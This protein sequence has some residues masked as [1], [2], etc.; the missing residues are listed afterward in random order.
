[1]T[2][3]IIWVLTAEH[4]NGWLR[5]VEVFASQEA[6]EKRKNEALIGRVPEDTVINI[7]PKKLQS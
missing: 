7:N 2:E 3:Q 6:A 1:M 4:K 5:W